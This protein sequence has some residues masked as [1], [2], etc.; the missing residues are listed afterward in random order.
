MLASPSPNAEETGPVGSSRDEGVIVGEDNDLV[1]T[2]TSP[3]VPEQPGSYTGELGTGVSDHGLVDVL[4]EDSRMSNPSEGG[5]APEW[6]EWR[7]T[8]DSSDPS[9]A[10]QSPALPNGELK[11]A[12]DQAHGEVNTDLAEPFPLAGDVVANGA[13][14]SPSSQQAE[15]E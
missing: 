9:E 1:D 3:E 6:V 11:E 13:K 10:D 7:E 15:S 4:K 2:A 12:E 14:E 5:K 8:S